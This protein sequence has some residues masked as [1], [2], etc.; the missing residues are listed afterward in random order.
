MSV[1]GISTSSFFEYDYESDS[2][3]SEMQQVQKEFQQLGE[4][5]KSGNLTAAQTD[6]VTLQQLGAPGTSTASSSSS[7][8]STQYTNPVAQAYSQ[9]SQDLQS[10]NLSAAQ[11]DYATIQQDLQQGPPTH[12]HHHHGDSGSNGNGISQ[13]FDELGQDLQSG[14]LTAAQ[15]AYSTLEQ[16]LES[17]QNSGTTSNSSSAA[18]SS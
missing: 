4:D 16:D 14:N 17:S 11:Q 5:L 10:G 3:Q 13:L 18:S 2:V 8:S 1:S 15:Q 6:L 7:S 12:H 9:L